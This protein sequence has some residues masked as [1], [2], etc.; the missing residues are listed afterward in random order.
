M[1]RIVACT[2]HDIGGFWVRTL[3]GRAL[4]KFSAGRRTLPVIVHSNTGGLPEA[5]NEALRHAPAEDRIVFTHDDVWIDDWFL[6][7]RIAEA[8]ARFDIVGV[9]GNRR[10]VPRQPSWI[11]VDE[12]LNMD[13]RQNLS[14]AIAH[15]DEVQTEISHYG[16]LPAEV[17]LLDGVFLAAEVRT[18]RD[19][20]VSFDPRFAFH[21]YDLDFCRSCERAGLSMGTWPIAVTHQSA[22]SFG[23]PEWMRAYQ[24]YLRKWGD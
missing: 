22:G 19:A 18:L 15:V 13:D 24:E 5:F 8:L 9:A 3:L 17:K 21:F 11:F 20:G 7:E 2:R 10:R 6:P 23:S 14:G 1:L 16:P 12:R 4:S